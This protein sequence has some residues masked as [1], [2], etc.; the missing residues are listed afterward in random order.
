MLL[1]CLGSG[2]EIG[3]HKRYHNYK[4]ITEV[5]VCITCVLIDLCYFFLNL[6]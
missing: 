2:A 5:K 3:K 1:K 6:N 4:L